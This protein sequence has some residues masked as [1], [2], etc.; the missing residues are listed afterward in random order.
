MWM[1]AS[2]AI[3]G[4][5]FSKLENHFAAS[6]LLRP[7]S[8]RKPLWSLWYRFCDHG[9]NNNPFSSQKKWNPVVEL[10]YRG[11][12]QFRQ[13]ESSIFTAMLFG[14]AWC[15]RWSKL[16]VLKPGFHLDRLLSRMSAWFH[17]LGTPSIRFNRRFLFRVRTTR[18]TMLRC[19][20]KRFVAHTVPGTWTVRGT[21]CAA[22]LRE[23]MPLLQSQH[24]EIV[25]TSVHLTVGNEALRRAH[26]SKS[27]LPAG[28]HLLKTS[29]EEMGRS[30]AFP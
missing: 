9:P 21:I 22:D 15:V 28:L 19:L 10:Y 4:E 17:Y 6:Y 30:S 20:R 26:H 23:K 11:Y 24:G 2:S 13:L 3:S 1:D 14:G 25:Q 27:K 7:F 16:V 5:V 29:H 12:K 18:N 8:C